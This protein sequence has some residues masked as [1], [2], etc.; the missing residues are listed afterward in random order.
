MFSKSRKM[1]AVKCRCK[2]EPPKPM[3]TLTEAEV[4][5]LQAAKTQAFNA[6]LHAWEAAEEATNAMKLA[7]SEYDAA[8]DAFEAA[9]TAFYGESPLN[10]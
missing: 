8:M 2:T 7:E 9:H 6:M 10:S 5:A 1:S 3:P 4:L